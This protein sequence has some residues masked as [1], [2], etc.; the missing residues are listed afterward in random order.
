MSSGEAEWGAAAER[1][2]VGCLWGGKVQWKKI[3]VIVAQPYEC[4]KKLLNC[5]LEAVIFFFFFFLS[6]DFIYV[7]YISIYFKGQKYPR[8]PCPDS[9]MIMSS[10]ITDPGQTRR[11][12]LA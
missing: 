4:A 9:L 5:T 1:Y 6:G 12:T 2:R 10:V 8:R 11:L 7:N 3:G